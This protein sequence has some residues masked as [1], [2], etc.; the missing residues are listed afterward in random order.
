MKAVDM[1]DNSSEEG[2][3]VTGV[4]GEPFR[5]DD[6]GNP[7]PGSQ[8]EQPTE[9]PSAEDVL[10]A[11]DKASDW[12]GAGDLLPTGIVPGGSGEIGGN[13]DETQKEIWREMERGEFGPGAGSTPAD[14]ETT[15]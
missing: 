5:V 13:D 11:F 12:G 6:Q 1:T 10:K 3:W 14:A 8:S 4:I 15:T 9:L 7:I 2:T